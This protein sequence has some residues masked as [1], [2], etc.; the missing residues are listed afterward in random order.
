MLSGVRSS[1]LASATKVRSRAN[2]ASSRAS[3]SF[4]VAPRRP[5]SSSAGGTGRRWPVRAGAIAA[6]RRRI[7]S[8]GRSAAAATA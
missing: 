5:I 8:T 4:S 7:A 1:W 6:A 3:M 2:A